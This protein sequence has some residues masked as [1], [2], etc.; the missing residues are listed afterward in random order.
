M[1]NIWTYVIMF[2][3]CFRDC[4]ADAIN[5]SNDVWLCQYIISCILVVLVHRDTSSLPLPTPVRPVHCQSMMW[6]CKLVITAKDAKDFLRS[7]TQF[8][9]RILHFFS[10]SYRT[11]HMLHQHQFTNL[12]VYVDGLFILFYLSSILCNLQQTFVCSTR[13]YNIQSISQ[14]WQLFS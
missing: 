12:F 13:A 3:L 5:L 8:M 4:M 11:Q 9:T 2:F 7:E 14:F 1:T 6:L 10:W